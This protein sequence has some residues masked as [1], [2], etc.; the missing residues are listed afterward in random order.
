MARVSTKAFS[1][2]RSFLC[3]R[4]SDS[5]GLPKSF[6]NKC[7]VGT[8]ECGYYL[9]SSSLQGCHQLRRRAHL[10]RRPPCSHES[11]NKNNNDYSCRKDDFPLEILQL[12]GRCLAL[13]QRRRKEIFVLWSG[14]DCDSVRRRVG[15]PTASKLE[16]P[17]GF[18]QKEPR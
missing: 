2:K 10:I 8:K 4:E 1:L 13:F 9:S 14:Q 16:A 12:R 17:L 6:G 15:R 5:L 11:Y 18:R 3:K 7:R